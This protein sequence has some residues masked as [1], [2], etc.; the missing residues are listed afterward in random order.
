MVFA[1]LFRG[2][3]VAARC[4]RHNERAFGRILDRRDGIWEAGGGATVSLSLV[5]LALPRA[6]QCANAQA[7][8]LGGL[9][10]WAQDPGCGRPGDLVATVLQ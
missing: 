5:L 6:A 9:G 1:G 4:S 10:V 3:R 2:N 7:G 8:G